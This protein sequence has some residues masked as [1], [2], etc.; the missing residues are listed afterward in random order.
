MIVIAKDAEHKLFDELQRCRREMP[1]Q[2]CFFMAFSKANV[3]KKKLFSCFL[4]FLHDIPESYA[5]EVYICQDIDVFVLMQGFM[6]RHFMDFLKK[7]SKELETDDLSR[8]SDVMEVGVHWAGLEKI[9]KD[10]IDCLERHQAQETEE[11]RKAEAEKSTLEALSTFNPDLVS[12]IAD[13]RHHRKNPVV[14]VLDD[15][16]ISRMLV[17]NV[18]REKYDLIYAK[19]GKSGLAE[20]VAGAPDVL[21]LDIGLP[22]I[23]GHDILECLF[24]I[25]PAAYVIMF[26]GRKDKENILKALEAGAQG[27]IGKPFTRDSLF[28]YIEKSPHIHEK[29]D[30]AENKKTAR[31]DAK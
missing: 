5:A 3:E 27:F 30:T 25:D 8:L 18:V 12:S 15:D 19:D 17:G 7:L 10:K 9:C 14:M 1:S 29:G 13:R 26:S 22:D 11:K 21:F 28:Q 4:N 31:V 2:R 16:Q 24:Q 20:Y 6:Q 23:N